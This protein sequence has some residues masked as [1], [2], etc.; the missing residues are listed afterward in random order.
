MPSRKPIRTVIVRTL[1]IA[2][3]AGMLLVGGAG[4]A[5]AATTDSNAVA[6]AA[7]CIDVWPF[8]PICLN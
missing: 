7:V 2:A 1:C 8:E 6:T 3:A 4:V 5:Q